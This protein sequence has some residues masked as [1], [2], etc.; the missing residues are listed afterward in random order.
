MVYIGMIRHALIC[1][2]RKNSAPPLT[3]GPE[4]RIVC[5]TPAQSPI[6]QDTQTAEGRKLISPLLVLF[7]LIL[8]GTSR[9]RTS[10]CC[11]RRPSGHR[12]RR[13]I[14]GQRI[15]AGIRHHTTVLPAA[16]RR[17]QLE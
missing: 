7:G 9:Y 10:G 15:A 3:P 2:W 14:R 17:F 16:E 4:L 11:R 5:K 8:R 12:D 1:I 6:V 13:R